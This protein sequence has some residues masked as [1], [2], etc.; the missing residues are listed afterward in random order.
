MVFAGLAFFLLIE[1]LFCFGEPHFQL[2]NLD[3]TGFRG[4]R[5][6][7]IIPLARCLIQAWT[8]VTPVRPIR[9]NPRLTLVLWGFC[10][11]YGGRGTFFS[12][13]LKNCGCVCVAGWAAGVRGS[14]CHRMGKACVSEAQKQREM[15]RRKRI[16]GDIFECL[17]L[18]TV[19]GK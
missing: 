7:T 11:C 8:H 4:G 9:V 14:L 3:G 19:M 18:A 15:V 1:I 6:G 16:H 2:L 5:G 17:Y 13:A 10:R 12:L